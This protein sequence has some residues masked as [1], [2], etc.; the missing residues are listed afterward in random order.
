VSEKN[1][2]KW[3][4]RR[5][6]SMSEKVLEKMFGKEFVEKYRKA[7]AKAEKIP[8]KRLEEIKKFAVENMDPDRFA[9]KYNNLD[10]LL[11]FAPRRENLLEIK[12]TSAGNYKVTA[13]WYGN[14]S[15]RG[16]Y[17][18]VFTGLE[19]DAE[20]IVRH[21][22]AVSL[23]VGKLRESMYEGDLTYNFRC[24]GVVPLEGDK[25]EFTRSGSEVEPANEEEIDLDELLE[26]GE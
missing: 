17:I 22:E 9:V 24:L 5:R 16:P 4:L 7:R 1:G 11:V 20:R 21:P 26:E 25:E 13:V 6:Y 19:E 14:Q 3:E 15:L 23:I 12:K 8:E 10:V 18:S 2:L